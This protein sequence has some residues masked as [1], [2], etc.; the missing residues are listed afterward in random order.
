MSAPARTRPFLKLRGRSFV[1]VVLAPEPPIDEW[2]GVLSAEM[3]R[4]PG[5]FA[6]RPAVVDRRGTVIAPGRVEGEGATA[7]C[8]RPRGT[9]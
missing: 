2:L 9:F 4:A 7:R 3:A 1:A 6:G 5:F 8:S